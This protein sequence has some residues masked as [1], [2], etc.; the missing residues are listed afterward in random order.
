LRVRMSHVAVVLGILSLFM[1][2]PAVAED[3]FGF[4]Q[5]DAGQRQVAVLVTS[6]EDLQA[7]I[8]ALFTE[9]APGTGTPWSQFQL[10]TS[11]AGTMNALQALATDVPEAT[12][13]PTSTWTTTTT[14]TASPGS[15]DGPIYFPT[16]TDRSPVRPTSTSSPLHPQTSTAIHSPTFTQTANE[17]QSMTDEPTITVTQIASQ[18]STVVPT[19]TPTPLPPTQDPCTGITLSHFRSQSNRVR[20]TLTNNSIANVIVSGL[21]LYWPLSNE[22]LKRVKFGSL[23]IWNEGST[24]SPTNVGGI[25]RSLRKNSSRDFTFYFDD[26]AAGSGYQLTVNLTN[27]CSVTANH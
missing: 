23:T 4:L 8:D 2:L 11:V 7:T 14:M 17:T 26:H 1:I 27:G 25:N 13:T 3:L 15:S 9:I 12:P 18:T 24:V 20:W 22:E 19:S 16:A 10:E 6:D 21:R 5:A